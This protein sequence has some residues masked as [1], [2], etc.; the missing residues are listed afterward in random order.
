MYYYYFFIFNS[1]ESECKVKEERTMCKILDKIKGKSADEL[2][3]QYYT[4]GELPIDVVEIAKNIGIE[5]G[6]I[7]FTKLESQ[8]LFKN[9][10]KENGHILGAVYISGEKLQIVYQDSFNDDCYLENISEVDKKKKLM[11]RQ[12]FTIAHEIAHCCLHIENE[13]CH[14]EYRTEE[15]NFNN[16]SEREANIFAGELLIPFAP[17]KIIIYS[18]FKKTVPIY[19]LAEY[20]FVSKHVME[21]RLNYL[22]K[23]KKCFS[24]IAFT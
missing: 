10:V 24:D 14:I 18:L 9:M 7:N 23:E 20:F 21:A 6:S 19:L 15:M 8:P 2:L 17:L 16:S 22:I 3:S 13:K 4:S 12:R 5:L 1:S 11:Q